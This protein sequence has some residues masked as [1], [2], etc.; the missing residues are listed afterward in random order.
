MHGV[1][2]AWE[3]YDGHVFQFIR[4]LQGTGQWPPRTDILILSA[5]FG[6]LHPSDPIPW[7]DEAMT[8][9]RAAEHRPGIAQSLSRLAHAQGY[10]D[11]FVLLEPAYVA[12]L[13]AVLPIR[14]ITLE[15]TLDEGA[16]SRLRDWVTS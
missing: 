10:E 15:T 5:R 7:Y 6:L 14:K 3:R 13:P 11:C 2:A 1:C 4:A 16:L 8:L 9:E 12:A